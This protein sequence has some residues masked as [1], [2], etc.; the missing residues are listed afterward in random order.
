[1]LRIPE[2]MG[3]AESDVFPINPD[4]GQMGL[5]EDGFRWE[6]SQAERS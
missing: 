3:K 6:P 5:L 1:M 4:L 2:P